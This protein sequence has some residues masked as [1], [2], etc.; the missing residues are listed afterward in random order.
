MAGVPAIS[1]NLD[2]LESLKTNFHS[3]LSRVYEKSKEAQDKA[4]QEVMNYK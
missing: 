3:L 4:E 1:V 2:D